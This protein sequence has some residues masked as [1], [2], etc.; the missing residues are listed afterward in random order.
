MVSALTTTEDRDTVYDS[1]T[2]RW[3]NRLLMI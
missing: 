3:V 1:Y 2:V